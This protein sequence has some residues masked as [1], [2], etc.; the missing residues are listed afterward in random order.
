VEELP[1]DRAAVAAH[2]ATRVVRYAGSFEGCGCGYNSCFKHPWEPPTDP[3]TLERAGKESRRLLREYAEK[4]GVRQIY[5]CWNG[6]EA[7]APESRTQIAPPALEDPTFPFTERVMLEIV[8]GER[9]AAAPG[10]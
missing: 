9:P 2:F 5:A 7:L 8:P 4:H 1:A 6:D 10:V 3:G